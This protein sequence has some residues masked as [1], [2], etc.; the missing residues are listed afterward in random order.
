MHVNLS[1][2]GS[3]PGPLYDPTFEHDACGTGFVVQRSGRRS[4]RVLQLALEA[5][6]N[7]A[8]RGAVAADG[9]SG[10]GAGI[11]TQ[12]PHK[13]IARDLAHLGVRAPASGDV[14][15]AMIFMPLRNLVHRERSQELFQQAIGEFGLEFLGWREVPV[16]LDALGEWAISLRPYI[17][18]A[19]I[20]RPPALAPGDSF[21]RAL[22]LARKRATQLCWAE[23]ITNFYIASLSS[24]TIVYKGLFMAPQLA[25][26]YVDVADPDFETGLAV[27]HQRYSTNTFPTWERAQPFRLLCHNGEINTLRGNINWMRAREADLVRSARP[28][29]GDAVALSAA[30]DQRAGQRFGDVGQ[31]AGLAGAVGPRY[32]P[33]AAD[34]GAARLGARPGAAGRGAGFLS[35]PCLSAGAVGRAGRAGLYRR[36]GGGQ[37][38]G[39]QRPAPGPLPVD[40]RRAGDHVLRGRLGACG[41]GARSCARA[42]WAPARC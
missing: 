33:C 20:G 13:L 26:F 34:A 37:R 5:L 19:F 36:P 24:K 27:F 8:H 40:R 23:S 6:C 32:Q 35:L 2:P 31:R 10:D 21:E 28:Y 7:H 3:A 29:F 39:P 11:L 41:R 15:V 4:H 17:V 16:N 14:A 22:Y 12:L 38:A 42:G 9:R 1:K 25:N 18:Q 30:G